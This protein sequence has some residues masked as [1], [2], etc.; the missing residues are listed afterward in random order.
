MLADNSHLS[1]NPITLRV[2][3]E[4]EHLLVF[5]KV[6]TQDMTAVHV[7]TWTQRKE[8]NKTF[9]TSGSLS[10]MP[11]IAESPLLD[12]WTSSQTLSDLGRKI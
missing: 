3:G 5:P 12:P 8:T 11:V 2:D 7:H 1:E 4:N 6:R 9:D 10:P